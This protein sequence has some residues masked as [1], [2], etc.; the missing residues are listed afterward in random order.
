M[1]PTIYQTNITKKK[2]EY[3]NKRL[4]KKKAEPKKRQVSKYCTKAIIIL[5]Y[6]YHY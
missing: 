1:R 3:I 6:Q 5:H 2:A 4:K